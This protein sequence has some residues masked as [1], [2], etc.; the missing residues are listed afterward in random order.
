VIPA[1]VDC[2]QRFEAE[3]FAPF[4]TALPSAIC[5]AAARCA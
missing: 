1:L 5:C 2:L 4:R 3:G